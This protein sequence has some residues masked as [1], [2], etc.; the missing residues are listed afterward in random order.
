MAQISSIN[1]SSAPSVDTSKFK[2]YK[3]INVK[4]VVTMKAHIRDDLKVGGSLPDKFSVS[5]TPTGISV[6]ITV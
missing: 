5:L 6:D 3:D 1:I 4:Q 2:L